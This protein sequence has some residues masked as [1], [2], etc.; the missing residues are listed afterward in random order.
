MLVIYQHSG[1]DVNTF[2]A[3]LP[4]AVGILPRSDRH[5][6]SYPTFPPAPRSLKH[7]SIIPHSI[8]HLQESRP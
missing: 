8:N 6:R 2:A 5:T 4:S 7:Y 1:P 3:E